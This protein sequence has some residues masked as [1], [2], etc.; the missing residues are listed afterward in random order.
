MKNTYKLVDQ[1]LLT[2]S[3]FQDEV[4]ASYDDLLS[5]FGEPNGEGDN[6]KVSTMW[7][8]EDDDKNFLTIYDYKET[9]L[10]SRGYPSVQAFR[11][12]PSY[13]WHIGG[14]RRLPAQRLKAFIL[15]SKKN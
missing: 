15:R 4:E 5:L 6:Y 7:V 1:A 8:L 2:D 11:A 12:R 13:V 14:T 10:Y 3:S 9:D